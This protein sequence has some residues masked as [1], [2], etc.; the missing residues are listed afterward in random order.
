MALLELAKAASSAKTIDKSQET[1]EEVVTITP[2]TLA[3]PLRSDVQIAE[4]NFNKKSGRP[5]LSGE[6]KMMRYN[7]LR[8]RLRHIISAE[9]QPTSVP[10][11]KPGLAL[12]G[13]K[14]L[15]LT[16][17]A[18]VYSERINGV[19]CFSIVSDLHIQ[20]LISNSGLSVEKMSMNIGTVVFML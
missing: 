18:K 15:I 16:A 14:L 9:I 13:S 17:E 7:R 3:T 10:D 8:I 4:G 5:E 11:D 20:D 6:E 19:Y 1:N 12:I 2:T